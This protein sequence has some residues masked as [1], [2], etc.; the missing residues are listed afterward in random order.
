M[1]NATVD[2][3]GRTRLSAEEA[4]TCGMG[5]AIHARVAPERTAIEDASG[6]HSFG[7]LNARANQLVR[8]LRARGLGPGDGVA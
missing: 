4:V 5:V 6:C 1:S 2:D 8:A 3:Q 7:E